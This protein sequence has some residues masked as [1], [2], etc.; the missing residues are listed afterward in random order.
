MS[1]KYDAM[2]LG[3]CTGLVF[4]LLA[5]ITY[6]GPPGGSQSAAQERAGSTS[7]SS[8]ERQDPASRD[9]SR[10]GLAGGASYGGR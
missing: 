1:H 9:F 3:I 4:L 2:V 7:A 8:G 10:A 5:A 6:P